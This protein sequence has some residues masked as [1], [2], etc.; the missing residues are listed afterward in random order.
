MC[1]PLLLL[2]SC[3][4]QSDGAKMMFRQVHWHGI[5][6]RRA[7]RKLNSNFPPF[8]VSFLMWI[9]FRYKPVTGCPSIT[10]ETKHIL[11][12]YHTTDNGPSTHIHLVH[13]AQCHCCWK[14]HYNQF[15]A[16][17]SGR[18]NA[19]THADQMPLITEPSALGE[20]PQLLSIDVWSINEGNIYFAIQTLEE[21]R[22]L[23][24]NNRFSANRRKTNWRIENVYML[25]KNPYST[26]NVC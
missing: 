4:R 12:M 1:W 21:N 11:H 2:L 17:K 14:S 20:N 19:A 8:T 6:Q 7:E 15:P 18:F 16:Q 26:D 22:K 10:K 3:W 25:E 13:V 23:Y 24:T 9:F 5:C